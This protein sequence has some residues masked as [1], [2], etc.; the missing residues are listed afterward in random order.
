MGLNPCCDG[1][2]LI[3]LSYQ[4]L[5]RIF[6]GLNPC[7]DGIRLIHIMKKIETSQELS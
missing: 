5:A 1:I 6:I 4:H 7:C 2:R 3:H